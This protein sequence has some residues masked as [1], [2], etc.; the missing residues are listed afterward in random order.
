MIKKTS[1]QFA[2]EHKIYGR[3][4]LLK[5]QTWRVNDITYGNTRDIIDINRDCKENCTKKEEGF[6]GLGSMTYKTTEPSIGIDYDDIVRLAKQANTEVVTEDDI[7]DI[8]SFNSKMK[9]NI[10][11]LDGLPSNVEISKE[12]IRSIKKVVEEINPFQDKNEN[13]KYAIDIKSQDFL[14]Y[15]GP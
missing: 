5:D 13:A 7:G 9:V 10:S 11:L 4:P 2:G 12:N 15:E 6:L 1:E 8:Q 14:I 3:Y